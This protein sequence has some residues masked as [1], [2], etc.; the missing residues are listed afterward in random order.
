M[1]PRGGVPERSNGSVL[2]TDEGSRPRGFESHP[3]RLGF[4]VPWN[5]L[6]H[7]LM[8]AR[9]LTQ[10]LALA[11]SAVAACALAATAAASTRAEA[12]GPWCGG[13]LWRLMTLSDPQRRS[14]VLH[15]T[16][17]SIADIAKLEAPTRVAQART[18]PFQRRVWQMRTVIDRYRIA[19][20]GEIVLILYS[21]DSAQYMDAYLPNPHCLGPRARDRTGLIA[22]RRQLTQHCPA[23]TP[24][25]Q[26]LG[27][28]VELAGVGFW[29]PSRATRGALTNGAELRP[30][31]NF[32]IISG[33][34]IG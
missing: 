5:A 32:K 16:P 28:T 4:A 2:K 22:A 34:G 10:M 23:A 31:T 29:N 1:C 18:T 27:I 26:L 17:S 30:L 8:P 14:V 20:N 3:R 33:C 24:A 9:R 6:R 15:A 11:V 19:S 7:L 21:I 13:T 25:W 12:P